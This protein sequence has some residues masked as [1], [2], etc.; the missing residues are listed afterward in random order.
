MRKIAFIFSI[1]AQN[2]TF[3]YFLTLCSLM[4]RASP[5]LYSK[6]K[7]DLAGRILCD[8]SSLEEDRNAALGVLSAWR[9]AH[10]YPMH[11]FKQRLKLVSENVDRHAVSAQRLKRVP[12]IIRKL[13]RKY[14]GRTPTMKLTQMQD[15]AGCRVVLSRLTLVRKLYQ[16]YYVLGNLK[17]EKVN[18]KDYISFPKPDGYRGI[19]LIYKYV[20]DKGKKEYNGLLV[21]VQLRSKLQHLW[22]TAVETVD[23]FTKQAIKSQQG[24][25][26]WVSFFR[27]V[28]SAFAQFERCPPLAGTPRHEKELYALIKEKERLLQVRSKMATW[29]ASIKQFDNLRHA[30]NLHFFLL[31]LDTVQE[32]LTISAYSKRQES[33][34]LLDYAR[35][36]KKIYGR[37]EYD[38]VLVG[39]DTLKDL[40]RAYPNYFLDTHEFLR[41][42][43]KILDTY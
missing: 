31:E 41:Y 40:K 9:A 28:S 10:S 14:D 18:E 36:E 38:V 8:A 13:H 37:R 42:L 27:L 16:D 4:K 21:E 35:A 15:I 5:H 1:F 34:A 3:K 22:A 17:H 39:V 19:H 29:A 6:S 26:D 33:K 2:V 11:V 24:Q 32:K 30:K 23:F 7:T 43:N 25:E 12:S 20:S